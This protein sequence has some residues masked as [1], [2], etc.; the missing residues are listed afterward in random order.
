MKLL[1]NT[2]G[3][4]FDSM[5]SG[6]EICMALTAFAATGDMAAVAQLEEQTG[7]HRGRLVEDFQDLIQLQ[8]QSAPDGHIQLALDELRAEWNGGAHLVF[9]GTTFWACD[10][11]VW[12]TRSSNDLKK[13]LLSR[14]IEAPAAY[15]EGKANTIV[16]GALRALETLRYKADFPSRP[17]T[18][19]R[20]SLTD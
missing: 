14:Q 8:H 13:R 20:D 1:F 3:A 9:D 4:P 19:K 5:S 10:G 11:R 2:T 16:A 12:Q 15:G 7:V 18:H 17:Q 6:A